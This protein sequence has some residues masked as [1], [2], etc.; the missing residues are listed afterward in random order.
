MKPAGQRI[1]LGLAAVG[2]LGAGFAAMVGRLVYIHVKLG[3]ELT[4]YADA[5]RQSEVRIPGRRGRIL[6]RRQRTLAG[7]LDVRTIYAD[8][9]LIPDPGQT[10]RD[11][12]LV[13]DVPYDDLISRLSRRST[14]YV[15][16]QRGATEEQ[17]SRAM[18]LRSSVRGLGVTMEPRRSYPMRSVAAHVVG[19]VG[20]EGTGLA[21]V[22]LR[23]DTYLRGRDG[24]RL[25]WRDPH[26]RPV[27]QEADSYVPPENGMDVV[28]TIDA[29]IQ[30]F[31]ERQL[32]ERVAL[33]AAESA[34]G[35]VMVPSTG[36]VLALA[37]YPAYDPAE[38]GKVAP[39]LL[40]NRVLTDPVEPGSIFKPFVLAKALAENLARPE[41]TIFC[42]NGLY[43]TGKRLLHDHHPYGA[44]TVEQVLAKSSNIGMAI[45]GQ[46]LGNQRM[47]DALYRFGFGR[48]TGIDLPGEGEGLMLPVKQW[49]SFSTTSVPMG[50]ELA[51]TPIQM[52]SA[53]CALVN[54]G[55]FV[56]PRVVR[57]IAS[58]SGEV[59][60]D[61]SRPENERT[62]LDP[63][64]AETMR[65]MLVKVVTE[66]TG[67][68][69]ELKHW[70]V[71]GKTGTAQVPRK[72][73][74][75]YDGYLASFIAAAPAHDPAVA[76]L[77]MVR[78]PSK[79]GYYGA[80]VSYTHLTLPTIYS[81]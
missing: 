18:E 38:A 7:S 69:C 60:E 13:L 81:V 46:R 23:Y 66:G 41:E 2:L 24:R 44:L 45:L 36:E 6:D 56:P 37:N 79:N 61:R 35:V 3:P 72:D 47:Y 14:R 65:A 64:V 73:R 51:V 50:Q 4:A 77:I 80:P 10:A 20:A 54:G 59:I 8:P 48:L 29:V 62:V 55:R 34:V 15:V 26:R 9:V 57:L 39:D 53:F 16:L 75:G 21:G 30:E 78:R 70:Q 31:L 63:Q 74:R 49:N 52:I 25:V 27:F 42:H 76:V 17:V 12:A 68:P 28:L 11:L 33:H 19:F 40:R 5:R 67:R 58:P 32:A 71:M 1:G 22:E 43:V